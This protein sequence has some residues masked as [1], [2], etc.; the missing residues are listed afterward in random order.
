M[1]AGDLN[2][3]AAFLARQTSRSFQRSCFGGPRR[4]PCAAGMSSRD[5]ESPRRLASRRGDAHP[6]LRWHR[7]ILLRS[8][9]AVAGTP[10]FFEC[11]LG[12]SAGGRRVARTFCGPS[13]SR[14]GE[15]HGRERLTNCGATLGNPNASLPR[16][17][18]V[19]HPRSGPTC[20]AVSHASFRAAYRGENV[21]RGWSLSL[22]FIPRVVRKLATASTESTPLDQRGH[23][24]RFVSLLLGEIPRLRDTT[25]GLRPSGPEIRRA[26]G[27]SS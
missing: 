1:N 5:R 20:S 2:L 11:S 3:I 7:G 14:P 22:P 21:G 13:R 24:I 10:E 27:H 17:T 8:W 4:C 16:E 18:E 26:C 6:G 25:E 15:R 23:S 9:D 12:E 19:A